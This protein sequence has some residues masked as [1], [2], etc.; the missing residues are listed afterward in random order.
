[1]F[2]LLQPVTGENEY[3]MKGEETIAARGLTPSFQIFSFSKAIMRVCVVIQDDIVP[4]LEAVLN[5]L[6]SILNAISKV[7]R[8]DQCRGVSLLGYL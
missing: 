6:T 5:K 7:K 1:M 8:F 3:V 2:N 4:Y